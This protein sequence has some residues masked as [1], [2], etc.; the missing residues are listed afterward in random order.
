MIAVIVLE[1]VG[2][3]SLAA[4]IYVLAS[5]GGFWSMR[6]DRPPEGLVPAKFVVVVIPARNEEEV[7]GQAVASLLQQENAVPIQLFVVDD[8]SIDAAVAEAGKHERL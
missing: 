8:H 2:A 7:I 6:V 5:R 3:M 4:W 1:I